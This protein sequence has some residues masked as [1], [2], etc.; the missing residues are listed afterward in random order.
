MDKDRAFMKAA[1]AASRR[2][3]DDI[4]GAVPRVGAVAVIGDSIV[5]EAFRG[6]IEPD[7]H[8]EYILLQKHLPDI[9]LVDATVY[10][11]LE[12]CTKRGKEKVPCVERLIG[13]K[14]RRV[15]IGML[16][17]NPIV[18]G[19]GFR[20]LRLA[21]I[22]TEMFPHDLMSEVEEVN[23]DFIRA[24]ELNPIHQITQEIAALAVRSSHQL[25]RASVEATLSKSLI[26]LRRIQSGQIPIDEREA[27]YFRRWLELVEN[28]A[29][30]EDVKAYIRLPA[31][32]PN[33]LLQTNWYTG[34]YARLRDLVASKKLTIRYTFLLRPKEPDEA[35]SKFLDRFKDFAEEIRIVDLKGA[36]LGP[37]QLRPS[38]VLFQNQRTAFTH[39]RGDNAVMS[40]ADQ[41]IFDDNYERLQTQYA[42]IELTSQ[43]Y[44]R[45]NASSSNVP[46]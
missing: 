35:S 31:F 23:H 42:T 20:K 18:R 30:V 34:F 5:G 45:R 22:D 8:A 41:W 4:T 12:P 10:T 6:E 16:D 19:L 7:Q 38:I 2:S 9:S 14:V 33:E 3:R 28:H 11:T 13:R 44:F 29:G 26:T 1:I 37:E 27:G 43:V 24:I 25:Q 39:D 17:P 40:E 15:V 21:N 46:S 36:Y 32:D